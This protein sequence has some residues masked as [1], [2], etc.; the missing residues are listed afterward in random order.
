MTE[1]LAWHDWKE[2]SYLQYTRSARGT[3]YDEYQ[4]RVLELVA[5]Q[6]FVSSREQAGL[7]GML[8]GV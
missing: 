2:S 4:R 5:F 1:R 3:S 6:P 8:Y 7:Q